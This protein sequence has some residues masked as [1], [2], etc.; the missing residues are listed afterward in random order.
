M[1]MGAHPALAKDIVRYVGQPVAVVVAATRYQARDA[2]ERVMV[3]YEELPAVVDPAKAMDPGAPQLH[4]EAPKNL[5][6]NWS[7]GDEKATDAALAKAAKIGQARRRQQPHH[8]E[9]DRAA[10]GAGHLRSRRGA[11]H[12]S[13]RLAEPARSSA[14]ALRLRRHC[15]RD[16]A[17]RD[18]ARRRRRLRL[19]DLHL[20]RGDGLLLGGEA[21]RPRRSNGPPTAANCSSPTPMA[22]T[23]SATPRWPSTRTTRSSG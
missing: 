10:C 6:Y 5:I 2:A 22:A 16:Q 14:G 11:L 3:E 7:I 19:E 13:R 17:A 20:S 12:A 23:M 18:R 21:R 15:A 9:R 8:P 4:P 1:K